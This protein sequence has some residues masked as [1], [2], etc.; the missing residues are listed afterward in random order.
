MVL[1]RI[2]KFW[3]WT[4]VKP[5]PLH[6][7]CMILSTYWSRYTNNILYS[8][9]ER[10]DMNYYKILDRIGRSFTMRPWSFDT[11]AKIDQNPLFFVIIMCYHAFFLVCCGWDASYIVSFHI[12]CQTTIY[13]LSLCHGHSWRVRLAKQETL[14]PPVHL[15]SPLVCRGPWMSTLVLY[16]WCPQWQC[17]SSSLFYIFVTLFSFAVWSW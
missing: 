15:V 14:T 13:T 6:S 10:F 5:R 11:V 16:C 8:K 17:I 3:P 9:Y 7:T 4:E 1:P 12:Q 2:H